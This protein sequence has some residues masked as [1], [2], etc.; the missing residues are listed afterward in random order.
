MSIETYNEFKLIGQGSYGCV[1]KPDIHT[2]QPNNISKIFSNEK[3]RDIEVMF[4]ENYVKRYNQN[5]IFVNSFKPFNIEPSNYSIYKNLITTCNMLEDNGYKIEDSLKT[6]TKARKI[7]AISMEAF[8]VSIQNN[9]DPIPNIL[10]KI[11]KIS[12]ALNQLHCNKVIHRDIKPDNMMLDKDYNMKIIDFGLMTYIENKYIIKSL[13]IFKYT[14]PYYPPEYKLIN[15][16]Y[17]LHDSP[18]D[19]LT[20]NIQRYIFET[21]KQNTEHIIDEILENRTHPKIIHFIPINSSSEER[22]AAEKFIYDVSNHILLFH[23]SKE[24]KFIEFIEHI[25][26]SMQPLVDV[27]GFGCVV[28]HISRTGNYDKETNESLLT[29][30]KGLTAINAYDRMQ[31]WTEFIKDHQDTPAKTIIKKSIISKII[32]KFTKSINNS[33]INNKSKQ[34]GNNSS[35]LIP[36]KGPELSTEER[37]KNMRKIIKNI[38]KEQS[39]ILS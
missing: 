28:Y 34:G 25:F 31:F 30:S 22:A 16:I 29:I 6:P 2:R 18:S 9:K 38:K 4:Y 39:T 11:H 10:E 37:Y 1:Y 13:K 36:P 24:V 3:D 27:Y 19:I 15:Y 14:Y 35:V 17:K 20:N 26:Y 23:A 21:L 7:Y 8:M 12:K 5:N 33:N 32:K